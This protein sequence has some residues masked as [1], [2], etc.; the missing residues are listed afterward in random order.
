MARTLA[1]ATRALEGG[2][3]RLGR[4]LPRLWLLSDPARLPDPAP[5]LARLPRGAGLIWRPYD[6]NRAEAL[7]RGR[8]LR[9][10]SRRRGVLLLVAADWRLAAALGADGV[11]LPEGLARQVPLAPLLA[12]RRSAPQRRLSVACHGARGLARAAALEADMAL[13]SPVFPTASHPGAAGVGPLRFALSAR[14]ARRPVVAL[15]GL[16]GPRSARLPP[17][18][19]VGLAGISGLV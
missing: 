17:G 13:L 4:P 15:G 7:R 14:R 16:T 5:V 1:E 6:L 11:H 12:W 19:A 3:D 2:R 8:R 18:A 9:G 10:L